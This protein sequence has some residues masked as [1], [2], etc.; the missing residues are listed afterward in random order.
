MAAG[1]TPLSTAAAFA[2]RAEM[3]GS[4]TMILGVG[5]N[6]CV[7]SLTAFLAPPRLARRKTLTL[8]LSLFPSPPLPLPPPLSSP[9]SRSSAPVHRDTLGGVSRIEKTARGKGKPVVS[10]GPSAR[11]G[12][13]PASVF[14][15]IPMRSLPL[16]EASGSRGAS[17][18]P[19]PTARRGFA[20]VRS[21][22]PATGGA[23][24][25][26]GATPGPSGGAKLS[27]SVKRKAGD[28]GEGS[29]AS[30]RRG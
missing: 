19:E 14:S 21:F 15:D 3:T 4:A 9:P 22:S 23:E 6:K 25:G 27:I 5:N 13:S 8:T 26:E 11:N 12:A 18:T 29:P 24:Q 20:P 28:E 17:G 30:K 7:L 10:P 1:D 16:P 2:A